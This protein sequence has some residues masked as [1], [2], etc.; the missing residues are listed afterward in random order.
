MELC[1]SD[2]RK[3]VDITYCAVLEILPPPGAS[4]YCLTWW[5]SL[6]LGVTGLMAL[7][8]RVKRAPCTKTRLNSLDFQWG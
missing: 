1:R 6:K 3:A 5:S 4:D 8:R 2:N 7:L